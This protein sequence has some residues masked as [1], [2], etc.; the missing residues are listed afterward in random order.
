MKKTFTYLR[1]LLVGL[2]AVTATGTAWADVT[3][4]TQ[5]YSDGVADWT[6]GNTGRYTV[7][8]NE[9]GYLTVNAVS[10]GNNG[11][12]I[13]GTTVNGKAAAGDDFASSDDFT[14][15]FDLQ[16]T[17]GNNQTTWFH[18]NDAANNGGAEAADKHILTLHQKAANGTEWEINGATDKTVSLA[19]N[20]WY[21]F[22]LSKSGSMLYLT[23]TP[24]AGGD[25][26]F[27]Q[28]T[29][30]VNSEKGGLGNMVFQTKRYYA[31]M[32]IDNVELRSLQDGDVPGGTA[33]K[34]TIKFRNESDEEIAS[35]VVTDAL[36]DDV[37]T[38]SAA[39]MNPI[40]FNDQKYIYSSGNEEI[41]LVE[42]A[43]SNVITLVF[44]EAATYTYKLTSSL[45]AEL[46]DGS[47]FEG[48]TVYLPYP[49]YELKDYILYQAVGGN[50]GDWF[51]DSYTLES[52][53]D[54][55]KTYN[56]TNIGNVVFYIEGEN[57]TGASVNNNERAA[58][59]RNSNGAVGYAAGTA[60]E[61]DLVITTLPAGSYKIVANVHTSTSAGGSTTIKLGDN[62]FVANGAASSYNVES[63]S[64][65]FTIIEST[66][67]ILQ[68]GGGKTNALDYV[69]VIRTDV[70]Y[71][72]I[73]EEGWATLYTD[74]ALDFS[75]VAG[76]TAYTA[77]CDGATVTLTEV[78]D[79]PAGT[80][81]VLKGTEGNHTI[82]VITSSDTDKGD[83]QGAA[84]ATAYNA[85]DG[86]TLY[87]LTKSGE[88]D[89][90]FAPVS[91][92]SIAAGKAFLKVADGG[93]SRLNV[94]IAGETTGIK[95]IEA[96]EAQEGIFNL[97]GQ[98]VAKAQKGLY[99]VN[100]KKA[101]VK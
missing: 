80:G 1:T 78:N 60:G 64:D 37:I 17:G 50:N 16:L 32:A 65:E 5:D 89:A 91:G 4:V 38:A 76:L 68:A 28:N 6:S 23:V 88:T 62:V 72:T 77:T 81:V 66:D 20:T 56:K 87:V 67:L 73:G 95:A 51:R 8:M 22:Q 54:E 61:N 63:T 2:M 52:N 98:R 58:D 74:Y 84:T 57:I 43:S 75:G 34:Y 12:T 19:K 79:V 94:V 55:T 92:G 33:T 14:L 47:D 71:A 27:A 96:Q 42:D 53:V 35:D 7:D 30:A 15:M 26:V 21:T 11:A 29:I 10:N 9:G 44:R 100:G 46:A 24:T 36:V 25:P 69:Y 83:L 82:P 70:A 49:K 41:T 86:Y 101:I 13:T 39:Q 59:T 45:G 3:P 85:F 31:Y 97:Q 18:I 40:F 90:Q 93:T 99:I 48:N